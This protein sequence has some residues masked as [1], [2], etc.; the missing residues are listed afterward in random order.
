MKDNS[1]KNCHWDYVSQEHMTAC[2]LDSGIPTLLTLQQKTLADLEKMHGMCF[3][4]FVM[5]H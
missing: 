3:E 4:H 2:D 1:K 5:L